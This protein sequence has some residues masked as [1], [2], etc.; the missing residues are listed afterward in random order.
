M[1]NFI[2]GA[3]I[4][5]VAI[6]VGFVLKVP[7]QYG[8]SPGPEHYNREYFYGG[9]IQG[10]EVTALATGT[11]L[12][13]KQVCDSSVITFTLTSAAGV[14]MTLPGT[15]ALFSTC[16]M[17]NGDSKTLLFRN[18]TTEAG[19]TTTIV[20][21]SGIDLVEPDGQNVVIAGLNDALITIHRTGANVATAIVNELI[22]AD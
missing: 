14:N 10:G 22:P 13:A 11:T 16:L 15:S 12:T 8:V 7:N 9:L 6:V 21:G 19:T 18:L 5:G 4:I 20:A 17:K 3:L 1:K 2:V